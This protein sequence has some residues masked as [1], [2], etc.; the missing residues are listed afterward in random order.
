[1]FSQWFR[2]GEAEMTT[3][4]CDPEWPGLVTEAY[5]EPL[6]AVP[7]EASSVLVGML[8]LVAHC[9]GCRARY[10]YGFHTAARG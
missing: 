9:T 6:E 7:A 1:M 10:P 8:G 2:G 3:C 5:G 4:A